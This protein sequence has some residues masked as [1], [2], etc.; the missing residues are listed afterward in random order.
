[1]KLLYNTGISAYSLAIKT[2]A[3][4]GYKKAKKWV[5]GR[6]KWRQNINIDNSKNII[7]IHTSSLGEYIMLKPIINEIL[8]SSDKIEI[9]LSFFSPSG[10]ENFKDN[11]PRIKAVYLPIDTRKNAIDFINIINPK[12]AI[13]VK[14]DFW[15]N[16]LSELQKKKIPTIVFSALLRKGQIYFNP[17][18]KWQKEILKKIDSLLVINKNVE[19]YL[20]SEEFKNIEVCGDTRFDQVLENKHYYKDEKIEQFIN[21]RKCIIIGSSWKNEEHLLKEIIDNISSYAIIIAPHDVSKNRINDIKKT[22]NNNTIKYSKLTDD[23]SL[24]NNKILII[25]SIGLLS[26]IYNYSDI[27]II[28]G[29]FSGKLHNILEPSSCNNAVLFGPKFDSF[30]EA[31]DMIE[32]EICCSFSTSSDLFDIINKLSEPS[33][34]KEAKNKCSNYISNNTGAV[35]IVIKHIENYTKAF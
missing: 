28:G 13:F 3:F 32:K 9:L 29:G 33:K 14:Y 31:V 24:C 22:F 5:L 26:N 10:F 35:N 6:Q 25:D 16:Y 12:L 27:A 34:L 17:I 7:W 8:N 11:N 21:N 20:L 19:K 1:M 18:F 4:C 30:P 2:V 23:D 15:F